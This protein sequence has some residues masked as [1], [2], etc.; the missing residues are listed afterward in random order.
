MCHGKELNTFRPPEMWQFNG[1]CVWQ[2]ACITCHFPGL[3]VI[4][5]LLQWPEKENLYLPPYIYLLYL[6][7]TGLCLVS[8]KHEVTCHQSLCDFLLC[9]NREGWW[10]C[11][12][13]RQLS[14][15]N[16]NFYWAVSGGFNCV[17]MACMCVSLCVNV[18]RV[19]PGKPLQEPRFG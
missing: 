14:A 10:I 3:P 15:H 2:Q 1:V 13:A 5:S 12:P 16:M 19:C 6:P 8:E 11:P 17:I 4:R 9:H 18:C 7:Q